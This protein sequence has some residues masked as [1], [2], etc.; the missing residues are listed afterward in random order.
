VKAEFERYEKIAQ[1]LEKLGVWLEPLKEKILS[2]KATLKDAQPKELMALLNELKSALE[3]M[4]IKNGER[5]K[6]E[7]ENRL[8]RVQ[9]EIAR[10]EKLGLEV[11]DFYAMVKKV[12][13]FVEA[14]NYVEACALI[15][16]LDESLTKAMEYRLR[17]VIEDVKQKLGLARKL[18]VAGDYNAEPLLSFADY[19]DK[20][21]MEETCTK[22]VEIEK[23]LDVENLAKVKAIYE[24]T[25]RLVHSLREIP[26]GYLIALERAKAMINTGKYLEAYV[27]IE[28][29]RNLLGAG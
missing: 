27:L 25:E 20:E 24:E 19:G 26:Q 2:G 7:T 14:H 8:A 10:W 16:A 18:G 3:E 28:R 13:E 5:L 22:L 23:M 29:C 9:T 11:N 12:G 4:N 17:E 15:Y 21:R 6:K 1:T